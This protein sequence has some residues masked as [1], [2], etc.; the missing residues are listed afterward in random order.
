[1]CAY[2]FCG[3]TNAFCGLFFKKNWEKKQYFH[4][5]CFVIYHSFICPLG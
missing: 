3:M 5:K 1:L 2:V 4:P